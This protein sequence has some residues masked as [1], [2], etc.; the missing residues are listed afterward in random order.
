MMHETYFRRLVDNNHLVHAYAFTGINTAE[1]EKTTEYLLSLL[2]C[3]NK[4]PEGQACGQCA[5]CQRIKEGN[6][7]DVLYIEPDG[8]S[9]RVDQIRELKQWV[10]TTPVET[11]FKMA[12][13]QQADLM[14]TSAS[15]ALL[16]VL[17]EPVDH[18]YMILWVNNQANLLPTIQSRVQMIGFDEGDYQEKQQIFV[19]QGYSSAHAFVLSHL[20]SENV[21]LLTAAYPPGDLD[22]WLRDYHYYY[23]LLV[24][25]EIQSFVTV[26]THIKK[27]L[28]PVPV[29]LLGIDYL[30]FINYHLLLKVSNDNEVEAPSMYEQFFNNLIKQKNPSVSL[31]LDIN[32]Y[33]LQTKQYIQANVS[34]QLALE[35][36][37]INICK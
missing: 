4:T 8:R 28:K 19:E 35:Q 24:Q 17:E 34:P 9:V 14:N 36:L 1:K 7:P 21:G 27:H 10:A 15:N 5:V 30:L 11:T 2:A 6:F 29:A 3:Q 13:I 26:E 12:V 33:L 31:L 32:Q 16:T 22:Q 20:P 37:T 18:V 23:Q 25:C